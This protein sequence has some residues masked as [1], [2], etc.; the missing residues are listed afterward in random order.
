[1][2]DQRHLEA[3]L[4]MLVAERG[5]ARLTIDAYRRDLADFTKFLSPRG[6][7]A[8]SADSDAIRALL[9]AGRPDMV[10]GWL[11][12]ASSQAGA[13]TKAA[14]AVAEL[15]PIVGLA[16]G[17]DAA[18]WDD[19]RYAAWRQS[20]DGA[21]EGMR[22]MRTAMLFGLMSALDRETPPQV[23]LTQLEGPEIVWVKTPPPALMRQLDLAADEGRV[24]ETVLLAL[25]ARVETRGGAPSPMTL[26]AAVSALNR[27]GLA[28]EAR[29]IA[30]EAVLSRE[31]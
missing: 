10:S 6:M 11:D 4:E 17:D 9:A 1:M 20:Q 29:A 15:S 3:F 26:S 21:S 18:P 27:V 22:R 31:F 13:N 5:R 2:N 28:A 30:I 14:A 12:L 19:A 16:D 23:L 24:G 25:G 8:S 7:A